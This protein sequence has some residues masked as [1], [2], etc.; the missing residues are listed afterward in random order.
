M[1]IATRSHRPPSMEG[2]DARNGTLALDDLGAASPSDPADPALSPVL[3]GA[4]DPAAR[5]VASH[6]TSP[7]VKSEWSAG[8]TCRTHAVL[9]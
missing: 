3:S 2:R 5:S 7:L 4:P 9:R 8:S 1:R 6:P